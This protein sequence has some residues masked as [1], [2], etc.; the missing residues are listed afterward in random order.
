MLSNLILL[1]IIVPKARIFSLTLALSSLGLQGIYYVRSYVY[2]L[3]KLF[4]AIHRGYYFRKA[5]SVF[6]ITKEVA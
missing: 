3:A 5:T 2:P 4:V 1:L 6:F